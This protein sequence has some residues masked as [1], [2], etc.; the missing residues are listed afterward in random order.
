M[1]QRASGAPVMVF[2][3]VAFD[4][5]A[6]T[7][8]TPRDRRSSSFGNRLFCGDCGTQLAMRTD[9]ETTSIDIAVATFDDPARVRP[10]FHIW[11]ESRIA[12]FEVADQCPRHRRS[13]GGE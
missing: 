2:C 3:T 5:F 9:D 7:R 12:W 1:C 6:W 10:A 4:A 13:R 8:G 11:D